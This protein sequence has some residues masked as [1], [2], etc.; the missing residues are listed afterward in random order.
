MSGT[1]D[2]EEPPCTAD[3]LLLVDL[4]YGELDADT[5][6]E[7]RG[8][9]S[10]DELRE[11]SNLRALFREL[12]D[13][14]PA[15]AISAK[16]LH[17]AAI[18]APAASAKSER[19]NAEKTGFWAW[20]TS[21]IQPVIAYPGL[22]AAATLVVVVGVAGTI[23]LS[24][25]DQVAK[26][27]APPPSAPEGAAATP[28]V[29]EESPKPTDDT[30]VRG[31]DDALEMQ[32][33]RTQ[34]ESAA[35]PDEDGD[36]FQAAEGSAVAAPNRP[37]KSKAKKSDRSRIANRKG[38]RGR[39]A[40]VFEETVGTGSGGASF[41]SERRGETEAKDAVTPAGDKSQ[42][43]PRRAPR[44]APQKA[45]TSQVEAVDRIAITSEDPAPDTRDQ[46]SEIDDASGGADKKTA[47]Q[48][49][50]RIRSLHSEARDAAR[51]GD[52]E[53]VRSIARRIRQLDESYYQKQF[54]KDARLSD[55]RAE[56]AR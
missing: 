46:D 14:E 32:Q 18:N 37:S 35:M 19:D 29:G 44:K 20:L 15:Q 31:N 16:L 7:A 27:E 2:I 45:P 39:T 6:E 49:R 28:M 25:R 56:L 4:L 38:S 43:P 13:E 55:C 24:G 9:V 12:P 47:D 34:R 1:K 23:Y 22:A 51:A 21:L 50:A 11:L 3:D 26:V 8:Q 30:P 40:G 48:R 42:P 52:C 10:E 33:A 5:E 41:Q 36:D 17:A 54:R 53:T